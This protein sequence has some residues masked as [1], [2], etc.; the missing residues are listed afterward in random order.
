L[1]GYWFNLGIG[2]ANYDK[3][4]CLSSVKHCAIVSYVIYLAV[5]WKGGIMKYQE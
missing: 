4:N 1:I 3:K 2:D 5:K